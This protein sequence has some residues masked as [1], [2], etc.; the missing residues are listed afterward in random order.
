MLQRVRV[1]ARPEVTDGL[2]N[3]R[4]LLV[5]ALTPLAF[6]LI[7]G[8]ITSSAGPAMVADDRYQIAVEGDLEGATVT[9]ERLSHPPGVRGD[10]EAPLRFVST[11]DASLA[12]TRD[13]DV[14]LVV[15][16]DLDASL[17]AGDD[18]AIVLHTKAEDRPSRAAASLLRAALF[19]EVRPLSSALDL[20]VT[21]VEYRKQDAAADDVRI[22]LAAGIAALVLLQAGVLVGTAAGRLTGRRAGGALVPLLLLPVSRRDLV[23][24]RAA[25]EVAL[26]AVTALP[27]VGLL[28]LATAAYVATRGDWVDAVLVLALVPL[29]FVATAL[30]L[31]TTGLA[32]GIRARSVQQVSALTAFGLVIVA[33]GARF[34][35]GSVTVGPSWLTVVP[36]VGPPLALARTLAGLGEPVGWALALVS[37]IGT[38]TA[39]GALAVRFLQGEHL[40]LRD[41]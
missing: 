6:L 23:A 26:G 11:D 20:G 28:T 24:A 13:A 39:V 15:P 37:T 30:P 7:V 1:L 12:I 16:D 32:V 5:R 38:T 17:A 10:A 9:L 34:V 19:D 25:S 27:L 29:G 3:R 35:A 14:G 22:A 18:V 33:L 31:V 8:A 36:V 21:S 2:R 4:L 40:A 41:A